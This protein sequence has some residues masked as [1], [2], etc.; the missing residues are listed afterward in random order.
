MRLNEVLLF[1]LLSILFYF[2]SLV[3]KQFNDNANYQLNK[4]SFKRIS[5]G[6][7]IFVLATVWIYIW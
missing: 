1:F 6:Y 3:E 7:S 4:P 2:R 5:K